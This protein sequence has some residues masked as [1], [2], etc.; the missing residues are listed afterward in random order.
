MS[1]P[2]A[3]YEVTV[4]SPDDDALLSSDILAFPGSSGD[5]WLACANTLRQWMT[6]LPDWDDEIDESPD[7]GTLRLAVEVALVL[8]H[9]RMAAPMRVLPDG[10][11]GLVFER[12]AGKLYETLTISA[13]GT[14]ELER[15]KESRLIESTPIEI[16]SLLHL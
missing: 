7:R 11:G 15:F 10:E 1:P 9:R 5:G 13:D 16:S 2:V 8:R 6:E 12:R 3:E 14:A 4:L